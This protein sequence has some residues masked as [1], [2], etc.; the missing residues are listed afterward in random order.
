MYSSYRNSPTDALRNFYGP[1]STTQLSSTATSNLYKPPMPSVSNLMTSNTSSYMGL[2]RMSPLPM[3]RYSY[4]GAL[5]SSSFDGDYMTLPIADTN[6]ANLTNLIAE[7]CQSISRSSNILNRQLSAD[8]ALSNANLNITNLFDENIESDIIKYDLLNEITTTATPTPFKY[9]N[10]YSQPSITEHLPTAMPI[11][12]YFNRNLPL[13]SSR[14]ISDDYLLSKPILS[15]N[16]NQLASSYV[17]DDYYT[18][19]QA[20]PFR[21]YSQHYSSIPCLPSQSYHTPFNRN[22]YQS[23]YQPPFSS[24]PPSISS[25]NRYTTYPNNYSS[26][27]NA[28]PPYYRTASRLDLD[29]PQSNEIKR[30]VSFKFD[31]DQMSFD[32]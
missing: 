27:F 16:Y 10:F 31:V 17:N 25:L 11:S 8:M 23:H 2:N 14:L 20:P 24:R 9:T 26:G 6:T 13:T 28:H 3:R 15:K 18:S 22:Y 21:T 29:K 7:T 5:P 1:T 4:S 32:R 12:S 30:Q 19:T